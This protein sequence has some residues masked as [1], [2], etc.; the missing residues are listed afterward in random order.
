VTDSASTRRRS[1]TTP[2]IGL[3]LTSLFDADLRVQLRNGRALA[4]SLVP[5]IVIMYSLGA[6]KRGALFPAST[7]LAFAV[8]L[9][10]MSVAILGYTATV[11][12]D[13]DT[14][15]FQRL[16]V[17]PAPTWAIMGSRL[18][19]QVLSIVVMTI[20]VFIVGGVIL[21]LTLSPGAYGLTMVVAVLGAAEFLCIGQAIVGLLKSADTVNAIGRLL[22]IPLFALGIFGTVSVFGSTLETIARW[23]PGGALTSMLTG[24]MAPATWNSDNWWSVLVSLA[25]SLVFVA[26]GIRWFQWETR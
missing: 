13:R 16:R 21:N 23:S 5:P 14:G 22:Y 15:V 9:G 7:R 3:I 12:R 8:G 11:A 24:A 20:V 26:V 2:P 25:Y 10:I 4:L 19:V 18:A 1:T 17:T 6:G